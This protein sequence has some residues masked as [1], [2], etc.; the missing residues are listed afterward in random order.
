MAESKLVGGFNPFEKY[1]RQNGNHPQRSGWK[2]Q[3]YLSCHHPGFQQTNEVEENQVS[4]NDNLPQ[5]GGENKKIFE[6]TTRI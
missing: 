3:Q 2:F 4:Q 5:I 1:D 6:T